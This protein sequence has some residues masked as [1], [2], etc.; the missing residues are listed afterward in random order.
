[1]NEVNGVSLRK[2]VEDSFQGVEGRG[3]AV[4]IVDPVTNEARGHLAWKINGHWK[5]ATGVGFPWKE[6]RKTTGWFGI[7]VVW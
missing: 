7:E 1:M 5:L 3:A 4:V 6:P 2:I